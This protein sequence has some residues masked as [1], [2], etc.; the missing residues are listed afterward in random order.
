MKTLRQIAA[1]LVLTRVSASLALILLE[2]ASSLLQAASFAIA[3]IGIAPVALVITGMSS[4]GRSRR[5]VQGDLARRNS[6]SLAAR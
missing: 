6:R 2:G 5:A 3:L 1:I 4:G